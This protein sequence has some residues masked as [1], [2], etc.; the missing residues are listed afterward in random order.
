MNIRSVTGFL[1]ASYP[2]D[3][4]AVA[5][6]GADLAHV[7]AALEA[8]GLAVQTLRLALQPFPT[9]AGTPQA[10]ADFAQDVQALAFA[11]G[12]DYVS[13]GPVR[14]SDD[15][16]WVEA[17]AAMLGATQN[18]FAGVEIANRADGLS[19]PR[20]RQAA[21]LIKQVS[22]LEANGFANLR[23]AALANV[24]PW[25][26]FFPAAYHGGGEPR[27]AL[28]T[29][30]AD[31]ALSAVA[32]AETL[33]GALRALVA[34]IEAAAGQAEAAVRRALEGRSARFAG[35][36]FSLAPFPDEARSI[37]GALQALGLPHVGAAGTLA[38]AAL[39]TDAIDRARFTR[40]GF[41][42]LMLPVLED[43]TLAREA[44]A[45][46]LTVTE[47]LSYSAVCG[48]G[49]DTIPL[50]GDVSEATV[51]AILLDVA[52]LALRLDKPLTARLM[53]LPGKQAGAPVDFDFEYFAS[54]RVL[55]VR[56]GGVSGLLAG[57]DAA[58]IGSIGERS[59]RRS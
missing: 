55:E 11:H 30:S 33:E 45:G 8:D 21:G 22:A 1:D 57:E 37:G 18:V 10:A 53:P 32:G 6:M 5:Q 56:E 14:A 42:G 4:D 27:I 31:L 59:Q 52:A 58:R 9:V 34:S 50:P 47:L 41:S 29:E 19:L 46:R 15:G 36:D 26:A 23:L 49:L 39:L 20:I 25:A 44:G 48:T 54:S 17:V 35:L 51:A 13:V 43:T 12:V 24:G 16:G 2:L 3:R 7:R 28:A 40:T 38:A